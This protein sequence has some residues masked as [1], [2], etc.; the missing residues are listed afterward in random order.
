MSEDELNVK[1]ASLLILAR[2]QSA[3]D[4]VINA[5]TEIMDDV[6][7]DGIECEFDGDRANSCDVGDD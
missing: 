2:K 4:G 5:I 6:E 3:S 1:L 7:I